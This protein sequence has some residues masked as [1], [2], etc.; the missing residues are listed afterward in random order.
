MGLDSNMHGVANLE[1]RIHYLS[2]KNAQL[3]KENS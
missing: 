1:Y 2:E 3:S